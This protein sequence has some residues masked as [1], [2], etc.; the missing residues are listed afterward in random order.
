MAANLWRPAGINNNVNNAQNWSLLAVPTAADGNVATFDNNILSGP[1]TLNA[2]FN[3][4]NVDFSTYNN[5]ITMTNSMTVAGNV[6]LG[7]GMIITGAGSLIISAACTL[8]SNGKDWPN[9]FTFNGGAF[10]LTLADN[11][12]TSG[13][14]TFN[15]ASGT[16]NVNGNTFTFNAGL[17]IGNSAPNIIAGTTTF[18][19]A[20][21]GTLTTVGIMKA[22]LTWNSGGTITLSGTITFNSAT[23]TYTAGTINAGSS[24]LVVG[25]TATLNTSGMSF[26]NVTLNG[27]S[28]ITLSSALDV[29]GNFV[30]GS[31]SS[32]TTING[33]FNITCAGNVT[34][35]ATTGIVAG[36]ATIVMDG[37]GTLSRSSSGVMAINISFNTAG[38]IT[39]SGSFIFRSKTWTV[40]AGTFVISSFTLTVNPSTPDTTTFTNNI[41]GACDFTSLTI[42]A[43]DSHTV[44]FNGSNGWTIPTITM[45][46]ASGA[47]PILK[48]KQGNTY[49]C[50][51]SFTVAHSGSDTANFCRVISDTGGSQA[52]FTLNQ[53]ASQNVDHCSATDIDSSAGQTIWSYHSSVL[54]T[55]ISNTLNWQELPTQPKTISYGA[56]T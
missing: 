31:S 42:S 12:S 44:Y 29:N 51:S 28:T 7:A 54:T 3:P 52:K 22:N 10:A 46:N 6:A 16:Q 11:C 14:A 39:L 24:T 40:T 18:K 19:M 17:T 53:G 32:T 27:S 35:A 48:L 49:I 20:G 9:A 37:T 25:A 30:C 50:S 21:T 36:T 55:P 13:L 43:T 4:N 5:T 34:V 23:L 1:V 41:S 45:T 38:T 56:F 26:N 47:N 8:T 33:A 2:A 15:G